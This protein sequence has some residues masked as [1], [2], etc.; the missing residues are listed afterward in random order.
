[1]NR[2]PLIASLALSLAA[3]PIRA[4][5]KPDPAAGRPRT[6]PPA[7]TPV[8]D[9]IA[10]YVS[11]Q[12]EY[13]RLRVDPRNRT[14]PDAPDR[15]VVFHGDEPVLDIGLRNESRLVHSDP[16]SDDGPM[17]EGVAE[18]AEIAPD[19]RSAA[20]LSTRYRRA[21]AD[22]IRPPGSKEPPPPTGATTL[23]LVNA[24]QPDA[25]FSVSIEDGRWVKE[26]L[27]LAA[28]NGLAVS[29][30]TG[31]DAPADLRIFGADGKESFRVSEVEASVKDLS[32]TN[33]GA[34]VA[35]DLA[36]PARPG[37]PERGVLVLDLLQGTRWTYTWSYGADGEPV[38]WALEESGVLE[39]RLPGRILRFDRNG[40]PIG[41]ARARSG[42]PPRAG[43]R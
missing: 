36:Y 33:N 31:L 24:R 43:R 6:P 12:P 30:T 2:A 25:R 41:S 17:E 39:V 18:S 4:G 8:A 16:S 9:R 21:S 27:P 3:L 5:A 29:T 15:L 10:L 20:I 28:E 14:A 35:A 26:V 13:G 40:T 42:P 38:S 7:E 37:L 19:D 22:E 11:G 34:F 1:M 32:A 23:T